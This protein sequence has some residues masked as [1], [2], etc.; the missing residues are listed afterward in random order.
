MKI[1]CADGKTL[2]HRRIRRNVYRVL[3]IIREKGYGVNGV[4]SNI[5]KHR[6]V[7]LYDLKRGLRRHQKRLNALRGKKA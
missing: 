4:D 1:L 7:A 3:R 5:R 2:D 6:H